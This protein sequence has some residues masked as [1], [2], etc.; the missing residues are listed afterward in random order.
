MKNTVNGV[1]I[2]IMIWHHLSFIVRFK[3]RGACRDD[4]K[5]KRGLQAMHLASSTRPTSLPARRSSILTS[6]VV[7]TRWKIADE[8]TADGTP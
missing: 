4:K 5:Q 6:H 7:S 3:R 8:R 1:E 2:K